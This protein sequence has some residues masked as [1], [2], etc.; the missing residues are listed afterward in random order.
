MAKKARNIYGGRPVERSD[1]P[2]VVK[3]QGV[4]SG[5]PVISGTRIMVRTIIEQYQLGNSIDNILWDFPQLSSAQVHD[6]L[7]YY[8]DHKKEM[9]RLL[10]QASYEH[11][12][13]IIEKIKHDR[14]ENISK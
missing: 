5:E 4:A 2:H 13:P 14:T 7:S 6:A 8:H 1:H 9:D 12:Q 10:E 11:W 3:V